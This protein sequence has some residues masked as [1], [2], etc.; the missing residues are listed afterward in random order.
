MFWA[1]LVANPLPPTPFRNFRFFEQNSVQVLACNLR[2]SR[3]ARSLRT[4]TH[5]RITSI[6][7]GRLAAGPTIRIKHL[8]KGTH[9]NGAPHQYFWQ[10][11]LTGNS[12]HDTQQKDYQ[13]NST[14]VS[15]RFAKKNFAPHRIGKRPH[16]EVALQNPKLREIQKHEKVTQ[17]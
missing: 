12:Y 7:V 3:R 1:L 15:V 9:S 5:K 16:P 4:R 2:N 8:R 17:E 14:G 6:M 13:I 11:L 10:R